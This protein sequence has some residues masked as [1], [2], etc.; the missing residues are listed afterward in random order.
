MRR[1]VFVKQVVTLSGAGLLAGHFRHF[2]NA[3]A[4]TPAGSEARSA[5]GFKPAF[6]LGAISDGFSSDL[7]EALRIMKGYGL[8]WVEI[9]QIWGKYNT[10][11]TPDEVRRVRRLLDQYGFRC[12]VV[13]SALYKCTLPGTVPSVKEADAYPYSGQMDLLK[14][15]ADR[16]HAWGTDKVRGFTFWRVTDPPSLFARIAEELSKA[17][18]RARSEGVRLVIEDE[19]SCNGGTGH[20][21]A[22]ILKLAPAPNLGF[23]W[24]V[25]NG[26]THGE[27]S[28]PDGYQALDKSRIWHLHLKGMA[29]S[30]GLKD[31]RET[32]ADQGEIDLAGQLRA[33]ARDHYQE[34]MSL[35]CEFEAP[36]M[37]HLETTRRSLEGLLRIVNQIS[38]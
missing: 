9:R 16:A 25:G 21:M 13:D 19:E 38:S 4:A 3:S 14:R 30:P 36:G 23:N 15:A 37:T 22:A 5:P 20:E 12:S 27:V 8:G 26:Y 35:E 34:S 17:A 18:D 7:E 2:A 6:K 31:C 29:C 11:A 10:E 33:L 1:R 28:Y 32:F 24:D